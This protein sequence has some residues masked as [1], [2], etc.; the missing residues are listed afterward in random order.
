MGMYTNNTFASLADIEFPTLEGYVGSIGAG[1]A[2]VEGYQND[3]ALFQAGIYGDFQEMAAIKEGAGDI[4]ALQE[5]SIKG[6]FDK[7]IEFFKKLG[8]KIKAIFTSFAAK[9]GQYL[10]KDSK[11]FVKKYRKVIFAAGRDYSNMK[12][13]YAE[14]IGSS[15]IT[16]V[17]YADININTRKVDTSKEW[18]REDAVEAVLKDNLGSLGASEV[19][20]IKE[21]LHEKMY[22]D[23]EVKDDWTLGDLS[24]IA[25]RLEG[26]TKAVSDIEK[27]NKKLQDT[28]K[29]V[30]AD[31]EKMQKTFTTAATS[32]DNFGNYSK[33]DNMTFGVTGRTSGDDA[34]TATRSAAPLKGFTKDGM[35]YEQKRLN[36]MQNMASVHQSVIMAFCS[37]VMTEAKFGIAQD[38][39]VWAQ[40]ASFRNVNKEDADLLA[41]IG[42]AADFETESDFDQMEFVVV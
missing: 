9:L 38:R 21:R 5:F 1:I 30:I 7:I 12:A 25:T 17:A 10:N 33:S 27:A 8:A 40:A 4:V 31:I 24:N 41:A 3:F 28:I 39:R 15:Y 20:E 13:K 34:G 29:K 19:G 11:D 32:K 23:E 6:V 14:P 37:A 2:L 36:Y 22:K 18:D 26:G 35:E 16:D 42:E